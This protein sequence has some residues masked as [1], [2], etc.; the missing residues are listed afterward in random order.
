MFPNSFYHANNCE[1]IIFDF[2]NF[3]FTKICNIYEFQ[4]ETT[5]ERDSSMVFL[6]TFLNSL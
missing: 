4:R 5:R 3:Y 6:N 1:N 2:D